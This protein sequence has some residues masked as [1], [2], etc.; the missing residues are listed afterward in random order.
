MLSCL[1]AQP[2]NT[3]EHVLQTGLVTQAAA[4]EVLP[5]PVRTYKTHIKHTDKSIPLLQL[6]HIKVHQCR[7]TYTT[8]GS[9]AS[10]YLWIL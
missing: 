4:D 6:L 10:A 8:Q 9:H 2:L 3:A 1:Q 5:S 7:Y